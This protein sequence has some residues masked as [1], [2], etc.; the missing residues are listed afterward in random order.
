MPT[1]DRA[2]AA[3]RFATLNV[4]LTFTE[5]VIREVYVTRGDSTV[6]YRPNTTKADD[7]LGVFLVAFDRL[8]F[9]DERGDTRAVINA[10]VMVVYETDIPAEERQ[11]FAI[12]AR[13]RAE[14]LMNEH[15][16]TQRE[17]FGLWFPTLE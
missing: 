3:V 9:S 6:E 17:A 8:T 16:A 7:E 15:L 11:T 2:N 5:S 10:S 13:K 4:E 1:P 14:R 12:E